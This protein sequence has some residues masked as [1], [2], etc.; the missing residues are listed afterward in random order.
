MIESLHAFRDGAHFQLVCQTNH[1]VNDG[2][3]I[4]A[5]RTIEVAYEASIDLDRVEWEAAQIAER[6]VGRPEIIK[7]DLDAKLP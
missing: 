5:L 6:G 4:R 2:D 1:G 7:R 3:A